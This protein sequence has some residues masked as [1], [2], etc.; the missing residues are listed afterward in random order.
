M[1]HSTRFPQLADAVKNTHMNTV[2]EEWTSKMAIVFLDS[3]G[4]NKYEITKIIDNAERS[5]SYSFL[6]KSSV[7]P[8]GFQLLIDLKKQGPSLFEEWKGCSMW[9][10]SI[11]IDHVVVIIMSLFFFRIFEGATQCN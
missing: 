11:D 2:S 7:N 4:I 9:Q 3:V 1:N 6:E 8:S 5:F 10:S